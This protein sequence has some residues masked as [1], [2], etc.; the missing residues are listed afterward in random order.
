VIINLTPHPLHIYAPDT[1][2][3]L[4]PDDGVDSLVIPPS[5]D[6]RSAR[7]GH[8]VV[9][10]GHQHEGVPIEDV[11]FGANT[12]SVDWLPQPVPDT[13]FVVSL[14]VGLAARHR[15]DLLVPHKY[16]R[17]LEGAIIGSRALAR[18]VH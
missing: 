1:P 4:S 12:E 7:L 18:P 17:D 6:Y 15:R 11:A 13:W 10:T 2:E 9:A 8:T 14:V 3:R 16:V 5:P